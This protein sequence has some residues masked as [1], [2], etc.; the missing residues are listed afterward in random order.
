MGINTSGISTGDCQPA[1]GKNPNPFN[2][3]S[4]T[5]TQ[6]GDFTIVWLTYPDCTNYEGQKILVFK[7][8]T[9][10]KIRRRKKID[11]HFSEKGQLRLVA[12][13]EP[14][15]EGWTFACSFAREAWRA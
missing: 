9:E 6:I 10:A 1:Q 15:D 2:F 13:F 12:R 7:G 5:T 3:R 8:T 14:T 4:L 11:P